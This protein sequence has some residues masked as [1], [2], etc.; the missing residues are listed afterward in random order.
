MPSYGMFLY[1]VYVI[2]W[3]QSDSDAMQHRQHLLT[4][5]KSLSMIWFKEIYG[6]L[7]LFIQRHLCRN[8]RGLV[9]VFPASGW[10]RTARTEWQSWQAPVP[11]SVIVDLYVH[12][13]E[14]RYP[15]ETHRS[16][17]FISIMLLKFLEL[18]ISKIFQN[19]VK[20]NGF[21]FVWRIWNIKYL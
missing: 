21:L 6:F 13:R 16:V 1:V 10:L 5:H 2:L 8:R 19:S 15:P 20:K 9:L 4:D 17:S 3:I 7:S 12:K 18:R 14:K 11:G